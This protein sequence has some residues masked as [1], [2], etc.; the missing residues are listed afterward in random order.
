MNNSFICAQCSG[1]HRELSHRVKSLSASTFTTSEVTAL[2][3]GGNLKAGKIWLAK[4]TPQ[5][6]IPDLTK[7]EGVRKFMR[8][9]YVEKRYLDKEAFSVLKKN[10]SLESLTGSDGKSSYSSPSTS[11]IS[12]GQ[13]GSISSP[14]TTLRGRRGSIKIDYPAFAVSAGSDTAAY[15]PKL[16]SQVPVSHNIDSVIMDSTQ[17]DFTRAFGNLSVI[18]EGLKSNAGQTSQPNNQPNHQPNHQPNNQPKATFNDIFSDSLYGPTSNPP[19]PLPPAQGISTSSMFDQTF[20]LGEQ[21]RTNSLP[22]AASSAGISSFDDI[23]QGYASPQPEQHS[24]QNLYALKRS[25]TAPAQTGSYLPYGSNDLLH[26]LAPAKPQNEFITNF[27]PQTIAKEQHPATQNPNPS[28]PFDGFFDH[29]PSPQPHTQ[30]ST[31]D[32]FD[33]LFGLTSSA[34]HAPTTVIDY[35]PSNGHTSMAMVENKRNRNSLTQFLHRSPP[36]SSNQAM[37][38]FLSEFSSGPT[39]QPYN[40]STS[41]NLFSESVANPSKSQPFDDFSFALDKGFST[42]TSQQSS[43]NPLAS[44]AFPPSSLSGNSLGQPMLK[45]NE[46]LGQTIYGSNTN[47][48]Q[49]SPSYLPTTTPNIN[50]NSIEPFPSN[51]AKPNPFSSPLSQSMNAFGRSSTLPTTSETSQSPFM[52]PNNSNLTNTSPHSFQSSPPSLTSPPLRKES[53]FMQPFASKSYSPSTS[54]PLSPNSVG[55][56]PFASNSEAPVNTPPNRSP[57]GINPFGLQ[58]RNT[59]EKNLVSSSSVFGN[60]TN[61]TFGTSSGSASP[62]SNQ[63]P[64]NSFLDELNPL[65]KNSNFGGASFNNENKWYH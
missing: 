7:A 31:T 38:D 8:Q 6:V 36:T 4:L 15:S 54:S 27:N 20:L 51:S 42:T 60:R 19:P 48:R 56:N 3:E 14:P 21:G 13:L 59:N 32:S 33:I 49:Q 12:L 41:T 39:E 10:Q 62:S 53:P 1:L 11:A 37:D 17:D 57:N 5:D 16:D 25:E 26:N 24:Q 45:S 22:I 35:P 40:N 55:T 9:K 30:P 63:Q 34:P 44:L 46:N 29:R 52:R 64:S 47:Y 58:G 2:K 23:F 18:P 28:D 65:K 50:S 61:N 43:Y